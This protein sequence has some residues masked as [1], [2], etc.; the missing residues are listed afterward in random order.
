M[1]NSLSQ[2]LLRATAPGVP[3]TYQGTELWDF[4]LVDP[5]NRRPV[6][7]EYRTRAWAE[8]D[9]SAK[10]DQLALARELV[11]EMD[12]GRIKLYTLSRA[13]RFRHE[14]ARLMAF[15]TYVPIE[16][17]GAQSGHAFCFVRSEGADA[18]LIVVPRLLANLNLRGH[19]PMGSEVWRDTAAMMPKELR[20]AAWTNVFT[21][22]AAT[23]AADGTIQLA[24]VLSSLPVALLVTK[25]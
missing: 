12:D 6:D 24:D 21:G 20:R 8:L 18:A 15:G 16:V 9:A 7:Y 14:H 5:D 2:T 17:L 11:R 25:S 22:E 13:Q 23:S 1:F 4:S 3:D 19:G 10:R